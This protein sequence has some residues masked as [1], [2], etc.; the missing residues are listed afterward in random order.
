[1]NTKYLI[2]LICVLFGFAH[3]LTS[4]FSK[5]DNVSLHHG[6]RGTSYIAASFVVI[7]M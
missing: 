3:L 1:M 2:W 7:A 5:D 4:W 6:T